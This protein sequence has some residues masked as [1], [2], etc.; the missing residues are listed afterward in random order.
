MKYMFHLLSVIP[1]HVA[2]FAGAWIE[3]AFSLTSATHYKS[4]PSRERGLK[5]PSIYISKNYFLS[6]PSRERGLKYNMEFD[7]RKIWD[8]APFAGAWI[9]ID[10]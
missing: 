3:I 7:L 6:L 5:Y 8:V 4:L 2:P 1:I 9:E 10:R